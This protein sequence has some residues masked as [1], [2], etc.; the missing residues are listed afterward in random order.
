MIVAD[1]TR[2][3]EWRQI[4]NGAGHDMARAATQYDITSGS[5]PH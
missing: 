1:D 2:A 3:P 5:L 4:T